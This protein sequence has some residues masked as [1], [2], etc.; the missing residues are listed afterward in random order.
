[1]VKKPASC[2]LETNGFLLPD[3]HPGY[4]AWEQYEANQRRLRENPKL[5]VRTAGTVRDEKV[6]RCFRDWF[7]AAYAAIA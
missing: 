2:F 1:M 6:R 4:I 7:Y 5:K 3:A